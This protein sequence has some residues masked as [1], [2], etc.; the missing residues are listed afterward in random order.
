MCPGFAYRLGCALGNYLLQ[1]RPGKSHFVVVG[2]DTRSSGIEICDALIAG[3][4]QHEVYVHHA[5]IVPTPAVAKAV[6]DQQADF[7]I[8]VTA[9]HNPPSDN[10]IKL[11]DHLACKLDPDEEIAIESLLDEEPAAP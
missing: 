8:A 1:T 2:R 5:N 9:S 10:G 6:L 3:L 11:F 4:N 7:G